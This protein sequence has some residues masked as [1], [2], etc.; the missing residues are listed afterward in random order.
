MEANLYANGM[1]IAV[2]ICM[3]RWGG[4]ADLGKTHVFLA[5]PSD[6]M[7]ANGCGLSVQCVTDDF[8]NLVRVP[9]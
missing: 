7:W 9:S 8:G 6:W 2:R 3:L 1:S 5:G 4:G